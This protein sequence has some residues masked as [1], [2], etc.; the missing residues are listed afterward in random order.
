MVAS[1]KKRTARLG[2]TAD[3]PQVA[4]RLTDAMIHA[5]LQSPPPHI[6]INRVINLHHIIRALLRDRTAVH[7]WLDRIAEK[8]KPEIEWYERQLRKDAATPEK[9][10]GRTKQLHRL[11]RDEA[12]ARDFAALIRAGHTTETARAKMGLGDVRARR[13]RKMAVQAGLLMPQ[14]R[15]RQNVPE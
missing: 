8:T 14:Q 3:L 2:S 6:P 9:K 10:A 4:T 7:E 1:R 5:A 13:I 11:A 12:M 15:T